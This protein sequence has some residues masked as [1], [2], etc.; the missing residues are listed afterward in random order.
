MD[1]RRIRRIYDK[2]AVKD[3]P[4]GHFEAKVQDLTDPAKMNRDAMAIVTKRKIDRAMEN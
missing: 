2:L 4:F 3:M 1:P